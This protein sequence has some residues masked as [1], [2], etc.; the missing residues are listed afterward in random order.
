AALEKTAF[1][2]AAVSRD[3]AFDGVAPLLPETAPHRLVFVDG[4]FAPRLSDIG[5][6]PEGVT[7]TG[8]AYLL[9]TA[10][11]LLEGT[12]GEIAQGPDQPLLDLNTALIEDGL[13]LFVPAGR[14]L[15]RSIEAIFLCG[16]SETA[17]ASHPRL[18]VQ[19]GEN[20]EALL[21]ERHYGLAQHGLAQHGLAQ[22]GLAQPGLAQSAYFANAVTEF[23]L[24]A[25]A[26]LGHCRIVAAATDGLH[27]AT[28]QGRI[29]AGARYDG[30]TLTLGAGLTRNEARL[31]L[32]GP[33]AFAGLHGAYLLGGSQHCDTTTEIRHR[34]PHTSCR[35]VFKGV[36][37]GNAR[38]VFQ[39][40]LV[41]ERDAQ[42]T[43]GHQLAKAL[44]LSDTAEF[45]AKPEL[46]IYADDVKCSH[47]AAAGE[48]DR[49]ALFYLT[50]RGLPKKAA[51]RL[52]VEAFL[53]EAIDEIATEA[54]REPIRRLVAERL[55][56][57][58]AQL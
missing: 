24:D 52:L 57:A 47:G 22:H 9:T 13:V 38:A 7:L 23:T 29:A 5:A 55:G 54:L 34:S 10:P 21:I 39:G 40:R 36:I 3:L 41:V 46:R 1:E 16:G 35:E 58:G 45:D 20:S 33:E 30:F 53:G 19:L 6:L 8:L 42:K 44:L 2:P 43:D 4:R 18:L 32:D 27:V 14:R 31:S 49:E 56:S 12:L 51:E 11:D 50:T 15:E 25:G 37:D 28:L 48:I 17:S 26:R